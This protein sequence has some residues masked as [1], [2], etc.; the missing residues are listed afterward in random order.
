MS[1]YIWRRKKD[2]ATI[3]SNT[4]FH[5][6]M[7]GGFKPCGTAIYGNKK[8]RKRLKRSILI[9]CEP[10]LRTP[11][12]ILSDGSSAEV[13][14]KSFTP[15]SEAK[16]IAMKDAVVLASG[17]TSVKSG[18]KRE[19]IWSARPA[20]ILL[21]PNAPMPYIAVM[22]AVKKRTDKVLRMI[23]S[24]HFE[25]LALS[26]TVSVTLTAKW[27]FWPL[28]TICNGIP[29]NKSALLRLR[30]IPQNEVLARYVTVASCSVTLVPNM[31]ILQL[32]N[33]RNKHLHRHNL[34]G[35]KVGLFSCS[36]IFSGG[37]AYEGI[38]LTINKIMAKGRKEVLKWP[39]KKRNFCRQSIG[40]KKH[41]HGTEW[42]NAKHEPGGWFRKVRSWKRCSRGRREQ[43]I[44]YYSNR[45]CMRS[46]SIPVKGALTHHRRRC[47]ALCEA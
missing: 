29:K 25:H 41:R 11:M 12:F 17:N 3:F 14:E 20:A 15:M 28:G 37:D 36:N 1:L 2:I 42:N 39:K 27:S 8:I 18:W 43:T 6:K 30:L 38:K 44:L 23:L 16:N 19:R 9:A 13:A 47:S 24:A 7:K 26:V 34:I 31:Q 46:Q 5:N 40:L 22:P 45:S 4:V 32:G 35:W 21:H 33:I 10:A